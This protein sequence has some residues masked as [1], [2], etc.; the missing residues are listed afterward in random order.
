MRVVFMGTP[1]FAVETL[2][3]ILE[4]GHEVAL[5]VTKQDKPKGR[6]NVIQMSP[7]KECALLHGIPVFQPRRVREAES[8]AHIRK[9]RPE[10]IITVAF[11]QILSKEIIEMPEYGCIN[12]HASLLPKYRGAAPIQWAVI[13]G[14]PVSGVTT[15]RM[16]EGIDTGD[17]IEQAKV[18]LSED[19]TG[20]SLFERLSKEGAKLC[21]HTMRSIK[22]GKAIYTRQQESEATHVGMIDKKM[23]D[24][25]WT[26]SAVSIERLI[27]GLSPW[28]SAYTKLNG[29]TFKIWRAKAEAGGNGKEAGKV[30]FVSKEELKVQTGE[31]MLSLLQ[32]Q[33]EGKKRMDA[34][35]FLRG[36]EISEGTVLIQDKKE[37]V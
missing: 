6:G 30:I 16:D 5:A 24:I 34:Q 10:I 25:D 18:S 23:G 17:I 15:M 22:E 31:G 33:L 36:Y 7:V 1:D 35:A 20:G 21:V 13:N 37:D 2:K 32:V 26:K 14:D 12:V 11:G 28:P 3:A 8:I 9:Y 27:R 4:A 19:E 29:K